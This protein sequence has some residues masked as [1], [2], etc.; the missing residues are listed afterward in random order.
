M[1]KPPKDA[2]AERFI[3]GEGAYTNSR[4]AVPYNDDKVFRIDP[5]PM[6]I[7]SIAVL[8]A[9]FVA[10]FGVFYWLGSAYGTANKTMVTLA[11]IGIGTMTCVLF[12][13]VTY[14]S[15]D[16]ARR[17]GPWLVVNKITKKVTLPREGLEF[18]AS[19]IVHLQYITTKRLDWG[20]VANNDRLS[21]LNLVTYANGERTRWPL[22][23]SIFNVKAFEYIV[24]PLLE[25]TEIP[26][27]RV[28]DEWLGWNTTETQLA[29]SHAVNRSGE[30]G[31][32]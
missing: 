24:D 18:D 15:F 1:A 22:L 26:V 19:E 28:V 10:F 30:V 13:A 31:R 12:T 16:K 8:N 2:D 17:L 20:G 27:V 14:Y 23:R 25:H 21:E 9:I 3:I 6:P 5:S 32:F 4:T 11:T 29:N 7:V